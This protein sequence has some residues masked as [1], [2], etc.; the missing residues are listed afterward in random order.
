KDR[1]TDDGSLVCSIFGPETMQE[2]Q[3]ALSAIHGRPVSL[4]SRFFPD[5]ATLREVLDGLFSKVAV[6]EWQLTRQYPSLTALLKQISK[7]G[8]AGWHPGQPLLN[9]HNLADLE[10][11]FSDHY[12]TCRVSYQIFMV[13]CSK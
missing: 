12:G 5:Q 8:T 9:R 10:N 7:T 3:G 11:W 6:T 4:P 1:L 13:N 2:L